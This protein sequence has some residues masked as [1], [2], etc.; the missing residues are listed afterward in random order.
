MKILDSQG[1]KVGYRGHR[2]VEWGEVTGMEGDAS[3]DW[4]IEQSDTG[5]EE[6]VAM[7]HNWSNI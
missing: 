4:G 7:S 1:C 5:V 6:T 3:F 2:G